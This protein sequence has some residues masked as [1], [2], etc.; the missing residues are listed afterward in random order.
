[1]IRKQIKRPLLPKPRNIQLP[2]QKNKKVP[3]IKVIFMSPTERSSESLGNG[4]RRHIFNDVEIPATDY[5]EIRLSIRNT[6][7]KPVS[8]GWSIYDFHQAY[9]VESYPRTNTEWVITV[10]NGTGIPRSITPYLI[11][12]S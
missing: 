3:K 12:K 5:A 11:T 7:R 4:F 1:M 9:A 8:A 2:I 10:Y 6:S